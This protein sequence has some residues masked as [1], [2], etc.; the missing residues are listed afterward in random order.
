MA[1]LILGQVTITYN[2]PNDVT[3]TPP[4]GQ[5][6]R[7]VQTITW[8]LVDASGLNAKFKV[9]GGI[10]FPWPPPSP[11]PPYSKWT[12][13]TPVGNETTYSADANDK[14]PHGQPRK[15]Y[16][17]DIHIM[18]DSAPGAEGPQVED[19]ISAH[20]ALRKRVEET[21][22]PPVENQPLP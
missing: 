14:I 22:D 12:G 11:P 1:D 3:L 17:Y 10:T 13:T 5:I 18:H 7:D 8:E 2:G 19:V 4:I 6:N 15:F 9:P 20:E 16:A 21:I